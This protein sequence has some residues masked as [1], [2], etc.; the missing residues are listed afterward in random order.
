MEVKVA[1]LHTLH[2]PSVHMR[3]QIFSQSCH[4]HD[5]IYRVNSAYLSSAI[6]QQMLPCGTL[7]KKEKK[8]S[9]RSQ[10]HFN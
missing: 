1:G 5:N 6:L 3:E 7:Q 8:R 2:Y 10:I 9:V 4:L